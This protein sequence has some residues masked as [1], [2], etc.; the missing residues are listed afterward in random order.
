M[1]KSD[2]LERTEVDLD[3]MFQMSIPCNRCDQ[4]ATY[5]SFGHAEN[6]CGQDQPGGHT[7][8]YY[9][10]TGCYTK[11]LTHIHNRIAENGGV[12]C[13]NCSRKFTTAPAFSNYRR[14]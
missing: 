14:F 7:T 6:D 12:A 10:C 5:R 2:T 13:K 3:A 8:P 4:P 11:W 1:S 9:K